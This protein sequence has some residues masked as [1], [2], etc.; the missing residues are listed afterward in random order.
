MGE[1]AS[2]IR[3]VS[4][5]AEAERVAVRDPERVAF[6]TQTTLSMEDTRPIIE[7]LQRRFPRIHVPAKDDICYATQNR[8]V[9]VR[10]LA[11]AG[12]G[13]PRGRLAQLVQLEPAGRGGAARGRARLPRGRRLRGRS[14]PGSTGVETVGITSGASAPEFLVD[15]IVRRSC[16]RGG[17]VEVEEVADGRRGRPLPAAAGGRRRDAVRPGPRPAASRPARERA[18]DEPAAAPRGKGRVRDGSLA[19]P[20][21]GDR[22]T[23]RA[24]GRPGRPR[25]A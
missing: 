13:H 17:A 9:A 4:S 8:Q 24:G 14:R 5:V 6:I 25:G 22:A 21:R 11:Q 18:V 12:A 23:V 3:L 7:T 16:A 20:R 15:E 1:A 19:R 10:A 2:Q